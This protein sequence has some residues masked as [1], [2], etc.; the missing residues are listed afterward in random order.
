[1][2]RTWWK[3]LDWSRSIRARLFWTLLLS[4]SL[5]L[6]AMN[7]TA[8]YI[9]IVPHPYYRFISYIPLIVFAAVF[10]IAFFLMMKSIV[11]YLWTLADVLLAIAKG[12]LNLRISGR[13]KDELGAVGQTINFM[14]SQLQGMMER[15]RLIEKSKMELITHV[16][17]DLRTPLTSMIG[18]LNLLRQDDYSDLEAHKRYIANTYNKTQQLK[19]LIDD[20][21]EYTRLMDGSMTLSLQRIDIRNLLEQIASEFEPIA[22]EHG[23]TVSKTLEEGHDADGK[24]AAD[25]DVEQIVRAI[26]NLLMNALKFSVENG[27]VTIRLQDRR[28]RFAISVENIGVPIGKEQESLLFERFY[29]AEESRSS[30]HLPGG[31]GLGLSIARNIAKLHGGTLRLDHDRG[32][33]TF[34][35]ELPKRA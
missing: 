17:H 29:K 22:M 1:M 4:F 23:L 32:R 10:L 7:I 2:N 20:L 26:D 12:K 33:F 14:A 8:Y 21:F 6:L 3:W 9:N 24:I 27:M 11:R 30:P 31:S 18:Y 13:R 34:E 16:S 19:K 15:E 35:L 5:A 25:I 28:N